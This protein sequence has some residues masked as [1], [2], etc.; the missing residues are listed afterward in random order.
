MSFLAHE[1]GRMID[2]LRFM[3][4]AESIK[5]HYNRIL[6]KKDPVSGRYGYTTYD[7]LVPGEDNFNTTPAALALP[8]Y[9]GLVPE[10]NLD[11]VRAMF[12][13]K[14]EAAGFIRS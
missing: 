11:D 5:R 12:R 13:E 2:E 6:L 7:V 3:A 10:E 8:L 9:L 14:M 1:N 4:R